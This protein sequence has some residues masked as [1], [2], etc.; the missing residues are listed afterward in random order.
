ME[1]VERMNAVVVRNLLQEQSKRSK[2]MKRDLY[3]M[4]VDRGRNVIVMGDLAI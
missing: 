1:E 4:D 3:A 2:R